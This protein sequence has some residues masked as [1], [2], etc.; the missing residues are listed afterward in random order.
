VGRAVHQGGGHA[1]IR[2]PTSNGL[3]IIAAAHGKRDNREC[4]NFLT[5]RDPIWSAAPSASNG[6][7]QD[8]C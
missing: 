8:G 4:P 1:V 6:S 3:R 5:Q 7:R 2:G